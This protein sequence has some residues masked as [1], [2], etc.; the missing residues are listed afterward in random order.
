MPYKKAA[1]GDP[2]KARYAS[3]KRPQEIQA[4]NTDPE[5]AQ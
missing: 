5:N 2:A 1:T 3:A 4:R